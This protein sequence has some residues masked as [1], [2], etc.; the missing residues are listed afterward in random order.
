[1]GGQSFQR[2]RACIADSLAHDRRARRLADASL[3]VLDRWKMANPPFQIL[4]WVR[5]GGGEDALMRF[6]E[7]GFREFEVPIKLLGGVRRSWTTGKIQAEIL[8]EGGPPVSKD[9]IRKALEWLRGRGLIRREMHGT[10]PV[11]RWR[12]LW[13]LEDSL[14]LGVLRAL[15]PGHVE[16][17]EDLLGLLEKGRKS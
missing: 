12:R 13:Q 8:E 17:A 6:D 10:R 16:V 9:T 14:A 7:E 11:Y 4:D 1:M 2:I 15:R 5:E 3:Q